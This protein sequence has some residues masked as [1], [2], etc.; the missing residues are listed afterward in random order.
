VAIALFAAAQDWLQRQG[1]TFMRGPM[2]PSIFYEAGL[3]IQGFDSPPTLMMT[4][5]P[6]YYPELVKYCGFRK[7][8]D[9][10]AYYLTRDYQMPPWALPLA[11]RLA[12]KTEV[13]VR[14]MN[15]KQFDA[16]VA[17][18]TDIFNECWANNWGFTPL[19]FDEMRDTFKDILPML[20][21]DLTFF[22]YYKDEAVGVCV[23]IPD[24]NPLLRHFNGKLGLSALIKKHLYWSEITGLRGLILGV[25]EQYRQMGLPLV[26][27][28]YLMQR[29][30]N[31]PQ[32]HYLEMGWNLEDN[33]AINR[34]YEEGGL[35][36]HKRFR[37][38]RKEIS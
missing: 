14:S 20:D 3:L 35:V 34:L 7:E 13:S 9:L 6:P 8:K 26:T 36:P 4:Y 22:L 32:Y 24:V 30:L 2:N 23:L 1:L 31:K 25:K 21:T 15:P 33:Y 19:T 28:H 16:E 12:A 18:A 5:N 29:L 17:L 10:Y 27:L 38:Y 11:E 37:L